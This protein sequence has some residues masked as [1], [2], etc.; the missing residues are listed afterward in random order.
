MANPREMNGI[1]AYLMVDSS[2]YAT[3][4]SLLSMV[5]LQLGK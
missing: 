3:G 5:A 2:S 1:L 4:R